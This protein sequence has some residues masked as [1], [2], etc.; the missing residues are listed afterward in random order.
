MLDFEFAQR[1][2]FNVTAI[3][4]GMNPLSDEAQVE[5]TVLDVNDNSPLFSRDVYSATVVEGDYRVNPI[6]I[7]LVRKYLHRCHKLT[8]HLQVNA[9]DIDSGEF[10]YVSYEVFPANDLFS[11]TK[12]ENGDGEV[13][14]EGVLDRETT[15]EYNIT[16]IARDGGD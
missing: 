15:E 11:V 16:I 1:Y 7:T 4:G 9:I 13:R 14:V 6:L 8:L 3:D 2:S 5:I 12:L 10:G